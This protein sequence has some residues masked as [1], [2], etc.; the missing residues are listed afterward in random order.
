MKRPAI[1]AVLCMAAVLVLTG[2]GKSAE[3]TDQ[4]AKGAS[5]MALFVESYF[6]SWYAFNPS[7]AT[8]AGFHEY[9]KQLE[10]RSATRVRDRI[11]E[12]EN[13]AAQIAQ[14]RKLPLRQQ[15]SIDAEIIENRIQAELLDL[16]TLRVWRSPLYYAGIAGN[17]VDLLM[18]R[19]FDSPATRLDRVTARIDKIPALLDAMR[20]NTQDPPKEFTDLAIILLRGSI[21]FFRDSVA[22]WAKAAAKDDVQAMAE[23]NAANRRAV[24]AIQL[25]AH[26]LETD[27]KRLST[28]SYAIGAD[29]YAK[30][31]KYEE[32]VEIPLDKLLAIGEQ[33][34]EQDH[35]AFIEVAKQVAPGKSPKDAMSV[36]EQQHP[37]ESGL[38]EFARNTLQGTKQFVESKKI[39]PVPSQ[40]L[41]KLEP[42]PPYARSG[43]FA[44]MD[45]PGAYENNAKEAFYY[46]T[47]VEPE[48]SAAQKTEHL[49]LYNRPVMDMITIHE[50][51]PGHYLQFLYA[52]QFPTKTRKL[53]YCGTNVEGWAHYA[54]QMML[55]EGFGGGDPKIRL[56]QLS[57]ALVRDAR[58]VAGIKLHTQG[59]SVDEATKLFEEKAF[60]QHANAFQ[61]AR[62]GTYN[63]TYLYYTLG[64]MMIYKLRDDYKQ[65]KGSDYSVGKFHEEFVKQGGI[66]LRLIRQI[67]LPGNKGSDL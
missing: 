33:R 66:P 14:L 37:T 47:P 45:T 22:T 41:P 12:L 11:A 54:E 53:V 42:T 62:R 3:S 16:K 36:L 24:E 40:I 26:H 67:L 15:D 29:N 32:L 13:Q 4:T 56:A 28:G 6:N 34:L 60:M 10:D 51:Y 17:A 46:V 25:M 18:K 50:A 61:E 43:S 48:W 38:M 55:E 39:V 57:E 20:D 58:Y 5:E 64:K 63:P 30:K 44:S 59:W 35:K 1:A 19:E 27:V 8:A 21:P 49:K 23:F 7:D 2:C 31:L 52:K 65:A 9:D